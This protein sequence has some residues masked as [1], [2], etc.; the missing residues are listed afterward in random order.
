MP[1]TTKRRQG[2]SGGQPWSILESTCTRTQAKSASGPKPGSSSS[3]GCAP[4]ARASR[5]GLGNGRGP[6]PH[7]ILDRKRVGGAMLRGARP[8]G[9][10]GGPELRADVRPAKPQSKDRPTRC[11]GPLRSLCARRI[12]ARRIEARKRAVRFEPKWRVREALVQTRTRQPSPTVGRGCASST[13]PAR[14]RDRITPSNTWKS[15]CFSAED[16]NRSAS[17]F[18]HDHDTPSSAGVAYGPGPRRAGHRA[19]PT[20]LRPFSTWCLRAVA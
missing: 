11:T 18:V 12:S 17:P 20:P 4:T 19:S 9:D 14:L 16:P 8:R 3:S 7:R 13:A 15:H 5:S 10:C 6:H 1:H 2:R